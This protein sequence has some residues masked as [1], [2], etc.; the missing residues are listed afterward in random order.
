MSK[1]QANSG[2]IKSNASTATRSHE[3]RPDSRPPRPPLRGHFRPFGAPDDGMPANVVAW[4]VFSSTISKS[5]SRVSTLTANSCRPVVPVPARTRVRRRLLDFVISGAAGRCPSRCPSLRCPLLRHPS[6]VTHRHSERQFVNPASSV[7]G[8]M[9]S[10]DFLVLNRDKRLLAAI[11]SLHDI[12]RPSR[13]RTGRTSGSPTIA[14]V[15]ANGRR[16]QNGPS[17]GSWAGTWDGRATC[18]TT[19]QPTS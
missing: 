15:P 13:A 10:V 12:G 18:S 9:A 6:D 17:R 4:S 2:S 8:K 14:D 5:L 16:R 11:G 3:A 1:L 7:S 19:R